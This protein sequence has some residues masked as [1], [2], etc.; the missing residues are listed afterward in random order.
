MLLLL[1]IIHIGTN[2][3]SSETSDE[4]NKNSG[5]HL[6]KGWLGPQDNRSD[7]NRNEFGADGYLVV[8][9]CVQA[10]RPLGGLAWGL[11]PV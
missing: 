4:N 6:G 3:K 8:L 11:L 10:S 2:N 5:R 1:L 7:C 9:F